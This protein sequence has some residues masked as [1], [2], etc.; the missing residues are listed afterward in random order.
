MAQKLNKEQKLLATLKS[1]L[2]AAEI[3]ITDLEI[4]LDY[5]Q[6]RNQVLLEDK[7]FFQE[8]YFQT[9]DKLS[10]LENSWYERFKRFFAQFNPGHTD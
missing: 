9:S 3:K 4:E 5:Q 6:D 8:R 10:R 7:N 1:Q 2:V